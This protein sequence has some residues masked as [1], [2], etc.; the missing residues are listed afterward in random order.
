[1]EKIGRLHKKQAVFIFLLLLSLPVLIISPSVSSET[2]DYDINTDG[3]CN[4]LD[5]VLIANRFDETGTPG[6][7]REDADKNGIV[8]IYDII[9]LSNHY[10]TSGWSNDMNRILKL[11]IAYSGA[12]NSANNR[13]YILE[14]FDVL[15]CPRYYTTQTQAMK[16]TKPDLII[17][18]YYD[19]V[20]ASNELDD[21][22]YINQHEDWFL[23]DIN[24]N[25]IKPLNYQTN[26]MMNPNSGWSSYYAQQCKQFLLDNPQFDGIFSDDVITDFDEIGME[27][28][29]PYSQIPSTIFTNWGTWMNQFIQ[30]TQTAIG[31][32]KVM[33]NA[34]KYTTYCQS[35]CHIHFW[36]GFIHH[37]GKAYNDNHYSVE[38][39]KYAINMLHSQAELGNVI[40]TNSGCADADA[41]PVEAKR[42]MLF[43]YACLAFA[44]ED[45]TKAYFSWNF[46]MDDNNH[47]WYPEMDMILGQ[48][49]GDYYKIA[50]PNIYG[51]EFANTYVVANFDPLNSGSVTFQLNGVSYTLNPR[52]ALF[53]SK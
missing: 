17:F 52:T 19:S 14:H 34:W 13:N 30:T 15:D 11:C 24:G 41:H 6:W 37:W 4:I 12:M 2:P 44:A 21:W 48:P 33:P 42:W 46:F 36:E 40:A 23:H 53:I 39:I 45:V 43:C 20:M 1:M 29:V 51:R 10:G 47:G 22:E 18:G 49:K 31:T 25:R 38:M 9:F 32:H 28:N 35:N 50:N 16:Q 26:Y 8:N 3:S 7:I 27:F 5:I